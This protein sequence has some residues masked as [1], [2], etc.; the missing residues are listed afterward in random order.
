M[1]VKFFKGKNLRILIIANSKIVFGK[2]LKNELMNTN[3]E[4]DASLLDFEFL[5]LYDKNN[6]ESTKYSQKFLTYKNIPKFS[7]FFRM[8][9][10][11][12][13]IQENNFDIVNIHISRWFYLMI[14][15]TLTKQKLVITFYGSDF[16]RTTNFIKNIQ[17]VIYKKADAITFTN[18]LTKDSFFK[19]YN[20]F[21]DKSYVCRFGLKTLDYIDKNRDKS[22]V[23][24]KKSLGY[25]TE[26]I[27]ITCGY[28]STKAQQHEKIIEN[29]M[30][31]DS[32]LL[33]KIQFIFP[34]TYGDNVHK[35]KIKTILKET[36]LDYIVLEDFLYANNNAYIKL[37]S[38]IMI[39]ILETDSFSG[40]MQEFLYAENIIITG[41]WLPYKVFDKEGI[42]YH[43]IN[44]Q[45]ELKNKL[46]ELCMNNNEYSKK[47]NKNLN[48]IYNLSSWNINIQNWENIFRLTEHKLNR[49][50]L[51]P[52]KVK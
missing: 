14:L 40:S 42:I 4:I 22:K 38:D 46:E 47:L 21:E 51:N 52:E 5:T 39:N 33:E 9:H 50:K 34:M 32:S 44:H 18:P 17:R 37:A 2:E 43:K 7:M 45:N 15:P 26:K 31:L 6:T 29:I 41:S 35:E 28:N 49:N 36:N 23:D 13:V 30:K 8:L 16:Y 11:K 20:N 19:Y 12:K 10:I 1:D 25:S 48:I 27:I 3:K 24:T